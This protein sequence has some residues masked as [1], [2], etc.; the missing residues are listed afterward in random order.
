[1]STTTT[2]RT[3]TQKGK[4]PDN[5]EG[6]STRP[7]P[8]DPGEVGDPNKPNPDPK[9]SES[10]EEDEEANFLHNIR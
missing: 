7:P 3:A 6:P 5:G 1:M 4:R 8:E 2:I 10:G 9:E